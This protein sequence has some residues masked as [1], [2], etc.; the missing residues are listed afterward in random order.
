[1]NET[2]QED[3]L[4][5]L[6]Q[7]ASR[8]QAPG[9]SPVGK[10]VLLPF[11]QMD[12]Y[13]FERLC[14]RLASRETDVI[15]A[16]RYG[17]RGQAQYGIDV[18]A[19]LRETGTYRVYQCK[20]YQKFTPENLVE[21]L[22]KFILDCQKAETRT[23]VQGA[24]WLNRAT[25]FVLCVTQ[26]LEKTQFEN[27]LRNAEHD[28]NGELELEVWDTVKLT[29]LL[30]T[31]PEVVEEFFGRDA[32]EKIC[33]R[34]SMLEIKAKL[35]YDPDVFGPSQLLVASNRVVP[36]A[37]RDDL[38]KKLLEWSQNPNTKF[39]AKL[40]SGAGGMG[41]TRF[42]LELAS[43][44]R[45]HGWLAGFVRDQDTRAQQQPEWQT[46]LERDLPTLIVMDYAETRESTLLA[47]LGMAQQRY[48]QRQHPIR[49]VMLAR[50]DEQ[51]EW[52]TTLK[53]QPML[54][55][56]TAIALPAPDTL[57]N[58]E[59]RQQAFKDAAQ[60]FSTAL[61]RPEAAPTSTNVNLERPIFER[62]LFVHMLAL[63]ACEGVHLN[64]QAG[65]VEVIDAIL[66]RERQHWRRHLN[67]HPNNL[68]SL[69]NRQGVELMLGL[70][71]LGYP[72]HN[73]NE[74][75]R[76]IEQVPV[77]GKDLADGPK[78]SLIKRLHAM[79][80]GP[81]YL[82]AIEPDLIAERLVQLTLE[83]PDHGEQML[84]F[85]FGKAGAEPDSL[86]VNPKQALAHL[87]RLAEWQPAALE[88]W[89]KV[90]TGRLNNFW[91]ATNEPLLI[92]AMQ[93]A[94]ES[95]MNG[96]TLGNL[97]AELLEESQDRNLAMRAKE[98]LPD[99]SVSLLNFTELVLRL[100]RAAMDD[101]VQYAKD[102]GD[103]AAVL[104]ELGRN[105]DALPEMTEVI[106][107]FRRLAAGNPETHLPS[108]ALYLNNQSNVQRELGD[109]GA[110]E[111]IKE[112]VQIRRVLVSKN[113][114]AFL[115]DLAMSLTNQSSCQSTLMGD[116]DGA[117]K[118]IKEAVQ[119]FRGLIIKNRDAFLPNFAR[120][121]SNQ[122][123]FQGDVGD[124]DGALETIKEA[125]QICRELA[126]K[127][128]DAFFPD[129]ARSLTNQS[130]R[131]S[132]VGDRNGAI[133]SA[134]ESLM[135]CQELSARVPGAFNVE[136]AT[137]AY[138]LSHRYLESGD[139]INA[140]KTAEEAVRVLEPNL[141]KHP[142]A[143]A[144]NMRIYV[145]HYETRCQAAGMPV[146]T[147]LLERIRQVLKPFDDQA[148]QVAKLMAGLPESVRKAFLSGDGERL[149]K[150]IA[151]LSEEESLE[152]M[153]LL[154][155]QAQAMGLDVQ[156][157]QDNQLQEVLEN[158]EP[159]LQ[160]IAAV[161]LGNNEP[162]AEI[163]DYLPTLEGNGWRIFVSV[164][165]IWAGVRDLS[166]LTA[167][168]D[169]QDSALVYRILEI[170]QATKM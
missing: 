143:V 43:T 128:R 93:V 23:D 106:G 97:L 110:F 98:K 118:T 15:D 141:L 59:Q 164:K 129:L 92:T 135:Y 60:A 29:E 35:E 27:I 146:D 53:K 65:G 151:Q 89:R 13:D 5:R 134:T 101:E 144:S 78:Q 61:K 148:S 163:E 124:R 157:T 123:V 45:G 26:A 67:A 31:E 90:F 149:I 36:F 152:V 100:A 74:A 150:A 32:S 140:I 112:A 91:E 52:F 83:Q 94:R 108:L 114:E 169:S 38:T 68:D 19:R 126:S 119:I 120:G 130:S 63:L 122:S 56:A 117:L 160:G 41:K 145:Q 96:T 12:E 132:E 11:E 154:A 33:N 70:V 82:N 49:I 17:T 2:N 42:M 55:K 54:G 99:Y 16:R 170:I 138:V 125:V 14:T 25:G 133:S 153:T 142:Q 37:G 7:T 58:L 121:L 81:R 72:V 4:E 44:L 115:Q 6:T 167:G 77:I 102:L 64:D 69:E 88:L 9:I 48:Q 51:S 104:S 109:R 62:V 40:I 47:L 159:L 84:E 57:E 111:T 105:V 66:E 20:R 8:V 30:K 75:Q 76:L 39:A 10:E 139:P 46:L 71:T 79:Y 3:V 136:H 161:A 158:F 34:A 168:L 1:V 86:R 87:V 103:H 162:R 137:A 156:S 50:A 116:R 21:V 18:T 166:T 28:L 155:A 95:A 113:R 147:D 24:Q 107:I 73:L 127:N 22:E 85:A 165:R 131:Q 80:P